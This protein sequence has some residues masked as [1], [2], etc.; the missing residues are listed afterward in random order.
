VQ[1]LGQL[2]PSAISHPHA[3][4]NGKFVWLR[5]ADKAQDMKLLQCMHFFRIGSRVPDISQ[6]AIEGANV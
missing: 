4:E 6:N 5:F 2:I 3:N 1:I